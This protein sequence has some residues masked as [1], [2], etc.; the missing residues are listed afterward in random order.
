MSELDA[1]KARIQADK[2]DFTPGHGYSTQS[3]RDREYLLTALE[4][5][6]ASAPIHLFTSTP[7]EYELY[8]AL[9]ADKADAA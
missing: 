6:K 8:K 7:S 4:N 1:I 9:A 2:D 3:I 5:A